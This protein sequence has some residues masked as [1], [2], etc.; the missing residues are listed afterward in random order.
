MGQLRPPKTGIKMIGARYLCNLNEKSGRMC[1]TCKRNILETLETRSVMTASQIFKRLETPI[2]RT[3]FRENVF[4]K[5]YWSALEITT[6][7]D[8]NIHILPPWGK[9]EVSLP[10]P[11]SQVSGD[12]GNSSES[13]TFVHRSLLRYIAYYHIHFSGSP[14]M[15]NVGGCLGK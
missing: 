2:K 3:I 14:N 6:T 4:G 1:K 13:S 15:G 8:S 11:S 12:E 9:R 7:S 5:R 10:L